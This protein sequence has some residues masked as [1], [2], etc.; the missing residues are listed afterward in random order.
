[1]LANV[2]ERS[3][4]HGARAVRVCFRHATLRPFIH[5]DGC[6]PTLFRGMMMSILNKQ[7]LQNAEQCVYTVLCAPLIAKVLQ[8]VLVVD[9][10][11]V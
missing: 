10:S 3:G 5:C 4:G 8:V 9:S 1:M 2:L 11:R 6:G 7:P